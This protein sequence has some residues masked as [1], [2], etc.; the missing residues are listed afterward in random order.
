MAIFGG[1]QDAAGN[2]D[3]WDWRHD[4]AGPDG[5]VKASL[6]SPNWPAGFTAGPG[7]TLRHEPGRPA[8]DWETA[9]DGAAKVTDE[10][11]GGPASP[12]GRIW[13]LPEPAT[14]AIWSSLGLLLGL[15][16]WRQRRMGAAEDGADARPPLATHRR[17]W[18][19]QQRL[20]IRRT[21][22]RG[23]RQEFGSGGL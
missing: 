17:P 22:E 3:S 16:M 4:V 12:A 2:Q 10:S 6:L 8:N 11:A 9:L 18:S 14:I 21:I 15:R 1:P 13:R 5:S 19:S 20:A 7:T 23:G